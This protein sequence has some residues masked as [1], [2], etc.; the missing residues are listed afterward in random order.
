MLGCM[1]H[2]IQMTAKYDFAKTVS[3]NTLPQFIT[4]SQIVVLPTRKRRALACT[5]M[6]ALASATGTPVHR[7]VAETRDLRPTA[8]CSHAV[9]H[10]SRPNEPSGAALRPTRCRASRC[11][12]FLLPGL[13]H[14]K[15][16][17]LFLR[18][19][20]RREDGEGT[21][22]KMLGWAVRLSSGSLG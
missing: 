21:K 8:R 13:I 14:Q 9:R 2:D 6:A 3:A 16:P 11:R 20:A 22:A 10:Q 7:G 1:G 19:Y 17:E 5:S 4:A 15:K 18:I 12:Y